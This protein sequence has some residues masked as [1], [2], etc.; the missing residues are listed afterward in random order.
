[1]RGKE[2]ESFHFCFLRFARSAIERVL[3]ALPSA[4]SLGTI[5]ARC[6]LQMAARRFDDLDHVAITR[7]VGEEF[8]TTT[9]RTRTARLYPHSRSIFTLAAAAARKMQR[10][11]NTATRIQAFVPFCRNC[12]RSTQSSPNITSP[13]IQHGLGGGSTA[14]KAGFSRPHDTAIAPERGR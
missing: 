7:I 3:G 13:R 2:R 14:G 1:V 6:I 8:P 11:R 4:H 5:Q 9:T 12:T 10:R